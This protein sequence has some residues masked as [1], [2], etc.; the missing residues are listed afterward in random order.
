MPTDTG[1][2]HTPKASQYL[3]QLCKHFAHKV[4]V[5]FDTH[6]GR[7]AFGSSVADLTASDDCL[8]ISITL[9]ED[10]PRPEALS[11]AL[12]DAHDVIDRHLAR[13]A[14]REDFTQ[15]AWASLRDQG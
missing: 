2:F 11:D 12:S 3:Q 5:E 6:K 8:T 9:S 14:F 10:T 13:F 1:T 7:V 15:M 4:E